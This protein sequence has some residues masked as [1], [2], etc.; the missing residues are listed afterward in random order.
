[1]CLWRLLVRQG[2]H[3]CCTPC[4]LYQV[5]G[6]ELRQRCQPGPQHVV[7]RLVL[8][9][10]V[11]DTQ[12]RATNVRLPSAYFSVMTP[13]APNLR[14]LK[15]W[16]MCDLISLIRLTN[17]SMIT[18]DGHRVSGT[19]V[20]PPLLSLVRQLPWTRNRFYARRLYLSLFFFYHPPQLNLWNDYPPVGNNIIIPLLVVSTQ[21]WRVTYFLTS[22]HRHCLAAF[23]S[24]SAFIC[25]S[26][27]ID[28][29]RCPY[30]H[31]IL[32][33]FFPLLTHDLRSVLFQYSLSRR[34]HRP[35]DFSPVIWHP[36]QDFYSSNTVIIEPWLY[37]PISIPFND[38][39]WSISG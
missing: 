27:S 10:T 25:T 35:F 24:V 18:I 3:R 33:A 22:I 16:S 5:P 14:S 20:C 32:W 11:S 31:G 4:S 26:A 38:R 23:P 21:G 9:K 30:S 19:T 17:L 7:R 28:L 2:F 29:I 8:V 37:V 34:M 15:Q 13:Y 6:L 39:W 1:M 12:H 36:K